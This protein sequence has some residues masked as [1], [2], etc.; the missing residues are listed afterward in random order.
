MN[1]GYQEIVDDRNMIVVGVVVSDRL[2]EL[3]VASDRW[4]IQVVACQCA[5]A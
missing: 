4:I 2:E 1:T 3:Q 5:P